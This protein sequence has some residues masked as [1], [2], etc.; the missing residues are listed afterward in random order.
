MTSAH[1]STNRL[2]MKTFFWVDLE[3]TGLDPHIH[4][5]LEVAVRVTDMEFN[6]LEQYEAVVYQPPEALAL[7]DD[8][9]KKTHGASGLTARIPHGK[10]LNEVERDLLEIIDRHFQKNQRVVLAGNSVGNDKA[11]ID[12]YFP[13]VSRRLHYRIIDV[14]SF[15]E[16]F[17]KKWGLKVEKANKH[18]AV[19]DIQESINE[20]K[21]YLS[22]LDPVRL[23]TVQ[24]AP[25]EGESPS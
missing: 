19:D 20:L 12:A 17:R 2:R 23:A 21:T 24:P 14:S 11:F 5:I 22:Y 16:V 8:W 25:E 7:M 6:T 1:K 18:R 15:K 3:M 10:Q 9:C 13:A 4:H